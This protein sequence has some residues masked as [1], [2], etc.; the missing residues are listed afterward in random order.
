MSNQRAKAIDTVLQV[1]EF[2]RAPYAWPG[3]YTKILVMHDA[4]ILCADCAKENFRQ[5]VSSTKSGARD[6]WQAEGVSLHQ[7]GPELYCAHC[8]KAIPSDYGDPEEEDRKALTVRDILH[9]TRSEFK[10]DPWGQC[11]QWLFLGAFLMFSV[12]MKKCQRVSHF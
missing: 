9:D 12:D 10:Y 5:I 3:G 2:I 6:G 1:K 8:N 7:E 11:M 4:E